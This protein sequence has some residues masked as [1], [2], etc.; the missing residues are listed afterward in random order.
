MKAVINSNFLIVNTF[1]ESLKDKSIFG[2][3][4]E[5]DLN[6]DNIVSLESDSSFFNERN[7]GPHLFFKEKTKFDWN[8]LIKDISYI[9]DFDQSHPLY[10]DFLQ[11]VKIE[12]LILETCLWE[13]TESN[14]LPSIFY[15]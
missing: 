2:K 1:D 5:I 7:P 3:I 12:Q 15:R 14:A 6:T 9:I 4:I 13:M 8:I 11:I 10:S